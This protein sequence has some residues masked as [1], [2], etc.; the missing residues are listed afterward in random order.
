MTLPH[1]HIGNVV[2]EGL[3]D[4]VKVDDAVKSKF[5]DLSIEAQT[6][7]GNY[8]VYQKLLKHLYLF[9]IKAYAKGT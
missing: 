2:T 9:I 1:D 6:Y 5:T 8:M 4:E 3:I 7:K